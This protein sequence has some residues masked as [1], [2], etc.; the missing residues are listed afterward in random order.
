M[1]WSE[2]FPGRGDSGRRKEEK[3]NKPDRHV[4][5]VLPRYCHF[6]DVPLPDLLRRGTAGFLQWTR[7]PRILQYYCRRK[8]DFL[9]RSW[10]F[11]HLG[12]SRYHYTSIHRQSYET[13]SKNI[14]IC[15]FLFIYY[16]IIFWQ[17]TSKYIKFYWYTWD[18]VSRFLFPFLLFPLRARLFEHYGRTEVLRTFALRVWK[19]WYWMRHQKPWDINILNDSY[20]D[21]KFLNFIFIYI[22]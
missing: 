10:F 1:W 14:Y 2:T 6:G 7:S 18:R 3:P 4:H 8:G 16:I 21:L 17:N 13:V 12:A 15:S 11:V 9:P 20:G 19:V 5:T 22:L